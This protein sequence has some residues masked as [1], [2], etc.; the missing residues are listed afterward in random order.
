MP[1]TDWQFWI[2]TIIAI[3]ALAMIGR[4]FYRKRKKR[5]GKRR[6][7]LTIEGKNLKR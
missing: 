7:Q 6:A 1:W 5:S 4:T 3:A 2:V